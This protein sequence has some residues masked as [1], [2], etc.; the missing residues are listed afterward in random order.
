MGVSTPKQKLPKQI[1]A[2]GGY[3]ASVILYKNS[4]NEFRLMEQ[5]APAVLDAL[6]PLLA[7]PEKS[8]SA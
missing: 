7:A 3:R 6:L 1:D 5:A 4:F 2:G 8:G